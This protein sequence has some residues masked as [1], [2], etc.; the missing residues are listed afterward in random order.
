MANR[1]MATTTDALPVR[2][3]SRRQASADNLDPQP[4][5][6]SQ[7]RQVRLCRLSTAAEHGEGMGR[8]QHGLWLPATAHN[9]AMLRWFMEA[10]AGK[11]GPNSHWIEERPSMALQRGSL[12]TH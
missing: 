4:S 3:T 8:Q 11:D 12:L 6:D 10:G 1:S 9:W 7:A 5:E 2:R